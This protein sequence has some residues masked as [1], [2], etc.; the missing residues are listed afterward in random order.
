MVGEDVANGDLWPNW[1]E[2]SEFR[3]I[4]D[5]SMSAAASE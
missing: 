3:A 2:G 1:N 4:R 5:Q